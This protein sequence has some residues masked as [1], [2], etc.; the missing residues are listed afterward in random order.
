N[1][2]FVDFY[3][4]IC[5]NFLI[6]K[7]RCNLMAKKN[8]TELGKYISEAR[9]KVGISQRELARRSNMDCA[10]VSRI[11]SGKRKKPNILYLKGISETLGLSL[12]KL[13]KLA[14]YNDVEINWGKDFSDRRST[15]DYQ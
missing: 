10:E 4:I 12:V 2:F 7:K 1:Y 14:G 8:T 11:E 5:Y 3:I 6:K 9:E 15:A 13:M